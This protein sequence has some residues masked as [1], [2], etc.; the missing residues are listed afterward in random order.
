MVKR[1]G[2]NSYV[3]INKVKIISREE[4]NHKSMKNLKD[5][6]MK[7]TENNHKKVKMKKY[8]QKDP[9]KN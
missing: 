1:K 5:G 9:A 6:T 4:K 3:K 8:K 7:I 2:I